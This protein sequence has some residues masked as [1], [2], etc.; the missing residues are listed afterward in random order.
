MDKFE[1]GQT[2][3]FLAYSEGEDNPQPIDEIY[4]N[5]ICVKRGNIKRIWKN[6]RIALHTGKV[7]FESHCHPHPNDCVAELIHHVERLEVEASDICEHDF[8]NTGTTCNWCGEK[9]SKCQ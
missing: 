3:Y 7:L 8:S 5:C 9:K 1:V 2:V 4:A 6:G